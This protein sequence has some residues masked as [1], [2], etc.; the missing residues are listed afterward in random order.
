MQGRLPPAAKEAQLTQ[1]LHFAYARPVSVKAPGLCLREI[2]A[3]SEKFFDSL[4]TLPS[5]LYEFCSIHSRNP[6]KDGIDYPALAKDVAQ[7]IDLRPFLKR[8]DFNSSST[9]YQLGIPG[10]PIA[11]LK[12][13]LLRDFQSHIIVPDDRLCPAIPPRLDYVLWIQNIIRF[14]TAAAGPKEVKRCNIIDAGTGASVI[15]P[16]LG[17]KVLPSDA[18]YVGTEVDQPSVD[19]AMGNVLRNQ[20]ESRIQVLKTELDGPLL[21]PEVWRLHES[22]TVL[23]CNPPFYSTAEEMEAA[24]ASKNRPCIQAL[25]GAPVETLTP[26]GATGFILPELRSRPEAPQHAHQVRRFSSLCGE[27]E[28]LEG[29]VAE[30]RNLEIENYAIAKFEHGQTTR[31]VIAWSF[32]GLH[33]PDKI[34]RAN[35]APELLHLLPCALSVGEED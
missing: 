12:A 28:V 34:A 15:Y 7:G 13:L 29:V 6:Y 4:P 8:Q 16:L 9:A 33:L 17:C 18:C 31:W 14:T 27:Q 23:M 32:E 19:C 26:D 5:Y 10:A 24:E 1:I 20:L 21:P 2:S 35:E 30:L 11:L 22:Y 3:N 25:L